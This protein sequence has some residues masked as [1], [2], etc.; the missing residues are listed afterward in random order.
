MDLMVYCFLDRLGKHFEAFCL[1]NIAVNARPVQNRQHV[2]TGMI[3]KNDG[4]YSL[5]RHFSRPLNEIGRRPVRKRHVRDDDRDGTGAKGGQ[6]FLHRAC[7]NDL[8][9]GQVEAQ[10]GNHHLAIDVVVLNKKNGLVF[11]G[12]GNDWGGHALDAV[13]DGRKYIGYNNYTL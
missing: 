11:E 7:L 8:K 10:C 13:F 1:F 3:A 4:P 5:S 2:L 6:G 9:T 12:G